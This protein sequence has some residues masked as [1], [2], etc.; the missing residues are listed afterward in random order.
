MSV[1]SA[2]RVFFLA[3]EI[4]GIISTSICA[5]KIMLLIFGFTE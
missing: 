2:R 5:A 4:I 3:L 1:R